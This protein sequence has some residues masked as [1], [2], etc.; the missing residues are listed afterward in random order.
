MSDLAIHPL[1]GATFGRRLALTAP[2]PIAALEREANRVCQA[3]Y[4]GHGFLLL[5]GL[6][7]IGADPAQ[8]VRLSKLFGPEV[9]DYRRTL[10]ARNKVHTEVPEIL[11]ISNTAPARQPSPKRPEPPLTADGAL[12]IRFPHR[13]GWHTDQSYRRPPPDISLFYCVQ[14]APIDH[15]QRDLVRGRQVRSGDVADHGARQSRTGIRRRSAELGAGGLTGRRFRRTEHA[16]R[17][18]AGALVDVTVL[19]PHPGAFGLPNRASISR[20]TRTALLVSSMSTSA[21]PTGAPSAMSRFSLTS[22]ARPSG[23]W[24]SASDTLAGTCLP[25]TQ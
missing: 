3:F 11:V 2:D 19:I 6:H 14:P 8:L 24:P 9:E 5:S 1:D 13:R 16:S 25:H 23:R 22:L 21:Q 12:P 4:D 20:R 15:P 7:E 17:S 10:T 18:Y